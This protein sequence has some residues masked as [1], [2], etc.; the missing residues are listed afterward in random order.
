M[1][2]LLD[3]TRE[4]DIPPKFLGPRLREEIQR[5]LKQEVE[6]ACNGQHG[7]LLAV[8]NITSWGKGMIREGVGSAVFTVGY[9]CIA[10]MPFKGEVLDATVKSVNKVRRAGAAP[11]HCCCAHVAAP[12]SRV[13]LIPE[14][15]RT[16]L[17]ACDG[18]LTASVPALCRWASLPRRG[19]SPSLCPTT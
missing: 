18:A 4:L 7:F 6:G 14:M 5:R 17:I 16:I 2:Y 10:F 13:P 15:Q 11:S 9:S 8:V 12:V 19:R 3:L 1:F